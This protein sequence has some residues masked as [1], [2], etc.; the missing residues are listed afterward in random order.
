MRITWVATLALAAFV[1]CDHGRSEVVAVAK[2]QAAFLVAETHS[3]WLEYREQIARE[4][5]ASRY[6]PAVRALHPK[7]VSASKEGVY[8]ETYTRYVESAGIFIRHDPAYEPP[9]SGDPGFELVAENV[10]WYFAP[11]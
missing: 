9:R 8:V 6:P 10:Y 11:G 2:P 1:A 3:L 4:V 7:H 5:P